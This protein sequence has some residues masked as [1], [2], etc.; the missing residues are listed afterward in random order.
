MKILKLERLLPTTNEI[1]AS[2]VGYEKGYSKAISD[3][4]ERLCYKIKSEIDDC[5]DE[6][7]WVDEIAEQLKE[8]ESE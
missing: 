1:I 3:F 6:L 7:Q 8:R 4:A 5:A 2:K